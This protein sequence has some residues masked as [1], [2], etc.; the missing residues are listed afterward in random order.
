[1][2]Y[3][4]PLGDMWGFCANRQLSQMLIGDITM[5]VLARRRFVAFTSGNKGKR[6]AVTV[7]GS[8]LTPNNKG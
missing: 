4:K 7:R 8:S 5:N 6:S 2:S 1:M 3:D